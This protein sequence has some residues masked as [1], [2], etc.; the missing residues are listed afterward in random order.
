MQ[1]KLLAVA[2]LS[3]FSGL[4]AAQS[5]NVTMYGTLLGDLQMMGATGGDGTSATAATGIPAGANSSFR[6]QAVGNGGLPAA[7]VSSLNGGAGTATAANN[8]LGFS[9]LNGTAAAAGTAPAAAANQAARLRM[10]PA[11]SNLGVRGT[12]DLGNGLSAW[13]QLELSAT[14]GGVPTFNGASHANAPSWRNSAVGLRSNTWG[15]A[16]I[17]QWDLPFNVAYG[18]NSTSARAAVPGTTTSGS[19]MGNTFLGQ[20]TVS[21]QDLAQSCTVAGGTAVAAAQC[22]AA[23]TS[24]DR[25]QSQTIQWWSPNWNGFD[26]RVAYSAAGNQFTADNRTATGKIAPNIWDLSFGYN[27]GGLDVIYAYERQKDILAQAAI[28][29]ATAGG[30]LAFASGVGVGAWNIASVSNAAGAGAAFGTQVTGSKATG[31]RLGAK[32]A[33]SNGFAISGLWESLKW[34]VDHTIFNPAAAT[35]TQAGLLTG[36]KKTAWKLGGS[37]TWSSHFVGLDYYRANNLKGG[38]QSVA[39]GAGANTSAFDGSATGARQF[40]LSYN[41]MMSKRTSIGGYYNRVN[42]DS[43]ASYGGQGFGATS[44][45]AGQTATTYGLTVRHSF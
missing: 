16:L 27:N 18:R 11:G 40:I 6:L 42:N 44:A 7:P 20:G 24:F 21:S 41:Y 3:A 9:Y 43:N 4:A 8:A 13:F 10:N 29:N 31:H 17:G 22:F 14:L 19:L 37:Y 38:I 2:V 28:G 33:F 32:Y 34:D 15:T 30:G 12:E 36:I 39:T 1:K 23:G 26:M 35:P 5:A 45:A 25:R